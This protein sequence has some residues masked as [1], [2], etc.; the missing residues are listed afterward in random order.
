MSFSGQ[1][2]ELPIGGL[3]FVKTYRA[4]TSACK[5]RSQQPA[6][7][8]DIGFSSL[9]ALQNAMTRRIVRGRGSRPL[10]RSKTKR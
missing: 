6:A 7:A 9:A 3:G 1:G 10:R 4:G 2:Q 8:V 5:Q